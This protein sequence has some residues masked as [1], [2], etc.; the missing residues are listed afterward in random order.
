M[1]NHFTLVARNPLPTGRQAEALRDLAKH[2]D[3][4]LRE[5]G[6]RLGISHVAALALLVQ[7]ERKGY[8]GRA[9][10]WV[11]TEPGRAWLKSAPRS[12]A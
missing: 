11:V 6:G 8:V 9:M 12:A 4:T 7:L 1:R 3:S 10:R 2:P 5:R